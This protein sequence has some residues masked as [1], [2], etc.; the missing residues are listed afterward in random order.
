[1]ARFLA[2]RC[3]QHR[4]AYRDVPDKYKAE[5]RQILIDEYGWT[6]KDFEEE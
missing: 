3:A 2:M 4:L 1:M 6:D 5:V